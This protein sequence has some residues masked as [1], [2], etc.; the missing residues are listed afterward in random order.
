MHKG[1]GTNSWK[2]SARQKHV[3]NLEFKKRRAQLGEHQPGMHGVTGKLQDKRGG[4]TDADHMNRSLRVKLRA[5][6]HFCVNGLSY[7]LVYLEHTM[8][9]LAE[10]RLCFTSK[11]GQ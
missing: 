2:T 3:T 7:L 1:V 8:L 11:P 5:L 4:K 6:F 9:L 10:G